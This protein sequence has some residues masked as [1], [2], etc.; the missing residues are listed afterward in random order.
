[1]T[2]D[3]LQGGFDA[4]PQQSARAFRDIMNAT[5]RPGMIAEIGGAVP[6]APLSIA[7]GVVLLTLCDPTTPVHLAGSFDCGPVCEWVAFHVGAPLA[8]PADCAFAV[9]AWADLVPITRFPLGTSEY[10]DRSA[11]LIIESVD[12]SQ[13]GATLTGPGIRKES[14][15]SLPEK[16]SFQENRRLFPLGLDFLF[17]SGNRLAALPRSTRVH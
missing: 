4:P 12:L 11:T 2:H 14:C 8:A 10:P 9:G 6:P 1:M 17:T 7:A 16:A 13:S 3:T 15:L 5:A